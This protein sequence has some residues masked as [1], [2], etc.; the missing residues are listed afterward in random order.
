MRDLGKFRRRSVRSVLKLF[1]ALFV[2]NLY[3][4][5]NKVKE[6]V[7]RDQFE[8]L[9]T[10]LTVRIFELVQDLFPAA[11]W[12][13]TVG[14]KVWLAWHNTVMWLSDKNKVEVYSL[15]EKNCRK[16]RSESWAWRG[17]D[18]WR[19]IS[20]SG[21]YGTQLQSFEDI[22]ILSMQNLCILDYDQIQYWYFFLN[23]KSSEPD[24][25]FTQFMGN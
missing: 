18:I 21:Y 23:P 25:S 1:N 15:S 6:I 13:S 12:Y 24:K 3:S 19:A 7:S 8:G 2:A 11:E 22:R 9:K 4:R 14:C 10:S 20:T 17:Y 16:L 5:T